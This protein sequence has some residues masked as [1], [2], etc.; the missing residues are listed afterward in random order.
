MS[1]SKLAAL[2]ACQLALVSP[3]F[4]QA[5]D[6]G[7]NPDVVIEG[8]REPEQQVEAMTR[9]IIR[10]QRGDLPM[11]RF[12]APIC[13]GVV[14]MQADYARTLIARMQETARLVRLPVGGEG[15]TV[16]VLVAFVHDGAENLDALRVR[17]PQLFA[18]LKD[19]E[20]ERIK[21]GNGVVQAWHGTEAKGADGMPFHGALI[22]TVATGMPRSVAKNTPFSAA[23]LDGQVRLDMTAAMVLIDAEMTPGKTLQQLAD[24]AAL[25]A[26]TSVYDT[27]AGGPSTVPTILSLFAD[28]DDP[29]AG[30][31]AFD[32]AFLEAAY[33]IPDT[34]SESQ[35]YDAT[36][37]R[38]R[39]MME[40]AGR[41]SDPAP[42]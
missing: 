32:R 17:E 24:Y 29:P 27:T 34:A 3:L 22:Q 37:N 23:R 8:T 10:P 5:N 13:I 30:L 7:E 6:R 33:F 4:A 39:E 9:A 14:G 25:R 12:Y 11:A 36:W 15:C 35:M 26:L 40:D 42:R 16:N 1:V 28:G 19:Y 31:T 20:F 21:R 18:T 2:I 41:E 38:Y